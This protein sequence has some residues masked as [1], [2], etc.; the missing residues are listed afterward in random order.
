MSTGQAQIVPGDL[1]AEF[2]EWQTDFKSQFQ[3]MTSQLEDMRGRVEG[4]RDLMVPFDHKFVAA[5]KALS[6]TA[7]Q[8]Y[9]V[10]ND[11][12]FPLFGDSEPL[13]M[14]KTDAQRP[15]IQRERVE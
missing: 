1:R 11:R 13:Q 14:K 8:I 10:V 5:V 3:N 12:S 9:M 2:R 7:L 15:E 6:E 4:L